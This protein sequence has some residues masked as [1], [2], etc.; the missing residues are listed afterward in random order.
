[1]GT[2]RTSSGRYSQQNGTRIQL[3]SKPLLATCQAVELA[4]L[5]SV[6]ALPPRVSG[7]RGSETT[8]CDNSCDDAAQREPARKWHF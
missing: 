8:S 1:M 7:G 6:H 2:R 5:L 4:W 3:L